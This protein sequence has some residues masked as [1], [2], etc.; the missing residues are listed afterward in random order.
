MASGSIT[1]WQIG[2]AKWKQWQIFTLLG[3]QI[4]ADPQITPNDCSHE[5]KDTCSLRKAM[6]NLD[7]IL[8]SRDITLL[9]EVRIGKAMV[10]LVVMYG[11]ES[12]II[13][14]AECW[15]ISIQF[16]AECFQFVVLEKTLES[17]L[18]CQDFKPVNTKGNQPWIFT[19]NTDAEAPIFWPPDAKSQLIG[20]D[21][22]AGKDWTQEENR[23][24]ED[25][26]VVWHPRLSGHEIEQ[27]LRDGEGQFPCCPWWKTAWHAAVH[28]VA[29]RQT[30][31]NY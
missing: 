27:T 14:K 3:S 22:D 11:Y 23:T 17:C 26:M 13:K 16:K 28:G 21:P 6:T 25:E 10:F 18:D 24:T 9:T 31:L 1:W 20:K 4:M 29:E 15:R 30:Q 5:L 7:S 12:W 19:G 8:R 2:G